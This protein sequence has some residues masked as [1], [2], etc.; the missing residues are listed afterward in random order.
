MRGGARSRTPQ[1]RGSDRS[2]RDAQRKTVFGSGEVG[3]ADRRPEAGRG[4]A[5]AA[6]V[7]LVGPCGPGDRVVAGE[8]PGGRGVRRR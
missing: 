6:G 2:R 7:M 4:A 1:I 8:Q 3:E 5:Q